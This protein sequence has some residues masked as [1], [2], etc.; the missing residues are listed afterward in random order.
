MASERFRAG[1]GAVIYRPGQGV[2]AFERSDFPGSWQLPQG[3]LEPGEGVQ[4]A[5]YREVEEETGLARRHLTLRH[6]VPVWMGYELPTEARSGKTSRGQVHR[7]FFLELVADESALSINS[8]GEFRDW[9]WTSL[10]ELASS[11]I[12]FRR[13]VYDRL[14]AIAADELS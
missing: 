12:G 9:R 5:V 4:E 10:E 3:G 1:V 6:E 13:P 2:L 8:G 11:T 14:A 7:W